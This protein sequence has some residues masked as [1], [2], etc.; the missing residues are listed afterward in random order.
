MT[1]VSLLG[2]Q[3]PTPYVK[4]TFDSLGVTGPVATIRAGWQEQEPDDADLDAHLGGSRNLRLY[5]RW[6]D[7]LDRDPEFFAADRQ[8]MAVLREMQDIYTV[9]LD[10]ALQAVYAVQRRPGHPDVHAAEL[11]DALAAVRALDDHH[12]DQTQAV[13]AEFYA[14]YPPDERDVVVEHR[15]AIA[16]ALADSPGVAIA[17][18]HVAVL[19]N[20]LH[21]FNI[22][23]LAGDRPVVAWSA[24]AMAVAERV[25]LFHDRAPQGP[26]HPEVL[27]AGLSLVHG[28]VP[29]PHARRRLLIDDHVRMAVLAQRFAP[30]ACV[31]LDQ[32][33]RVDYAAGATTCPPG[34]LAIDEDGRVAARAA[35]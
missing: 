28:I 21:L 1:V 12:F 20:C 35:A 15:N 6:L 32:G 34:V 7:V 27:D 4:E 25:V 8:R 26:G 13:H 16:R 22:A 19:I 10:Y 3:R 31:P 5:I 14:A 18:G 29:L 17:G 30:A 24:G 2:P 11:A 33:A 23:A 9:R